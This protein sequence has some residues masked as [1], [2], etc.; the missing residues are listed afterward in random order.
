MPVTSPALRITLS[1]TPTWR[2]PSATPPSLKPAAARSGRLYLSGSLSR[3]TVAEK[4][5]R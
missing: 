1:P 4:S 3:D 2:L 5:K